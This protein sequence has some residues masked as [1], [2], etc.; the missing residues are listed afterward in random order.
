M[1]YISTLARFH[2][3]RHHPQLIHIIYVVNSLTDSNMQSSFFY[4]NYTV[5]NYD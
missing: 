1:H 3:E 5:A 2:F 4:S